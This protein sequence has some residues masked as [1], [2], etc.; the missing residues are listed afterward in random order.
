M[1]NADIL[2]AVRWLFFSA[3]DFSERGF[4]CAADTGSRIFFGGDFWVGSLLSDSFVAGIFLYAS[5]GGDSF[6]Y[7]A[8]VDRKTFGSPFTQLFAPGW[9]CFPSPA[10]DTQGQGGISFA[11]SQACTEPLPFE[12]IRIVDNTTKA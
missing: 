9:L 12:Q 1:Y 8:T 7:L 4:F 10:P 6:V 3:G 2:C 5:F 11:V